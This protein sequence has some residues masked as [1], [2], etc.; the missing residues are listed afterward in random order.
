MFRR[1]MLAITFVAALGAAGLATPN[2]AEAR[3]W[4][5]GGYYSGYYY[6]PR[7]YGG[8]VGPYRTYYPG[9]YVRRYYRPRIYDPYYAPY[10]GPYYRAPGYYYRPAPRVAFRVVY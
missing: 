9:G 6:G 8:Y 2:T 5:R 4:D 1:I 7:V 3:R 10:Y